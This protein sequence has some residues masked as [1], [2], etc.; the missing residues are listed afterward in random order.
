M[1]TNLGQFRLLTL[2]C[3]FKMMC[4]FDLRHFTK[5]NSTD[6]LQSAFR[7]GSLKLRGIVSTAFVN[8]VQRK[9]L[10]LCIVDV[11]ACRQAEVGI[12]KFAIAVR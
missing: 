2:R 10:Y 1:Q 4:I 11:G 5:T 9:L 12:D 3:G 8:I 7:Y 6:V